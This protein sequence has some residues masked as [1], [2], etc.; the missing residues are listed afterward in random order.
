MAHERKL[1]TDE[2]RARYPDTDGFYPD[3]SV[4]ED[5]QPDS[6]L[7]CTCSPSCN[8]RCAGECGCAACTVAFHVFYDDMPYVFLSDGT[9]DEERALRAYRFG[10]YSPE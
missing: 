2:G 4:K 8:K 9:V 1:P 3:L 7:P 10:I 6:D 5:N